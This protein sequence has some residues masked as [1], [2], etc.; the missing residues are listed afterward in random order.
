MPLSKR[1]DTYFIAAGEHSG[2]LLGAELVLALRERMPKVMPFGIVGEAMTRARV[3]A[4]AHTSALSVMGISEVLKKL[5]GLRMLEARLLAWVDQLQPRFAVLID[6][7]GFN[8][9]LGEQLHLRGVPVYQYVAP[10]V[11]AWGEGRVEQLRTNFDMVLGILPFEEEFFKA[12]GV[13][14]TYVGSPLKDRIDKVIIKRASI[15]L[16]GHR[17]VIACLP[18]SR[19]SEIALNLPTLVSVQK[20]VAQALPEALFVVPVSPNIDMETI[21]QVLRS[22]SGHIL[23]PRPLGTV[24]DLKVDAW[25][26]AGLHFVRGMSLEIMATA[27]VAVVTSGTATLECALIGTPLVVVYTTTELT[28]QIA[29][30]VVK[31]PYASL[32]NLLAGTPLVREF[33]QEFSHL[34]VANEVLSLLQDH[35]RNQAMRL[36][37]EEMR[38]QLKGMAAATA[39][40]MI[41]AAHPALKGAASVP[42]SGAGGA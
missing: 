38:E 19:V 22:T 31:V 7:P 25:E 42:V 3:E 24:F 1:K 17:P 14:Y 37:F 40:E 18:G 16:P 23:T 4:V 30:R 34:D 20:L 32:V 8:M 5:A 10:K 36:R 13:K 29:K 41:V 39:A 21:A 2:D 33:L 35:A 15:G 26:A 28:Y 27:D 11:W 6:N 12:R 9:R